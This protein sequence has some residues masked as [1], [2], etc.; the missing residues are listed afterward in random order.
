M[1]QEMLL[2]WATLI[3]VGGPSCTAVEGGH[4]HPA[5][6]LARERGAP[7]SD[8]GVFYCGPSSGG[9]GAQ[10]SFQE[11][12]EWPLPSGA[13]GLQSTGQLAAHFSDPLRNFQKY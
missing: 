7:H 5:L 9:P 8:P 13:G 12:L 1:V 10:G 11:G 6:P 3:W 4:P 2:S